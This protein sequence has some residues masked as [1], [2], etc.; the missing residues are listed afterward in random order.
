RQSEAH[1]PW[2][3]EANIRQALSAIATQM[4]RPDELRSWLAKYSIPQEFS[5]KNV[6]IIMAGNLPLVSFHDLLCALASGRCATVKLSGKDRFLLP[7]LAKYLC[8]IDYRFEGRIR[9]ADTLCDVD[10]VIATGSNNSSRYFQSEYGHLP[11]LFR[12]SRTSIGVVSGNESDDELQL[13]AHDALDYFGM[14]SRS[15]GKIFVPQG[16]DISRLQQFFVAHAELRRH[17]AYNDCCRYAQAMHAMRGRDF[18]DFGSCIASFCSELYSPVGELFLQAYANSDELRS[19]LAQHQS[20]L[21]C[22]S[23]AA[24]I[25]GFE[26]LCVHFGRSQLPHLTDYADG[27]DVMAF[28]G[29][30]EQ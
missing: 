12:Q 14:G 23:T 20:E 22:V 15:V 5:T 1:N 27:V 30:M 21:Q 24:P 2:F 16:Y 4:L 25:A 26:Q 3:T 29:D 28:L 6:G 13:L 19:Y 11:H 18:I 17:A 9:F 7:M 10:V 8:Q